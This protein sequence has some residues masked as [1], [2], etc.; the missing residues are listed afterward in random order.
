VS[1]YDHLKDFFDPQ[2]LVAA[3]EDTSGTD[4]DRFSDYPAITGSY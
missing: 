2:L 3:N 4:I 1:L